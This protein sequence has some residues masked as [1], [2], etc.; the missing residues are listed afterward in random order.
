[1]RKG[2]NILFCDVCGKQRDWSIE[3]DKFYW[4]TLNNWNFTKT[5]Y[6]CSIKCGHQILHKVIDVEGIK[7]YINEC[8][9]E[10]E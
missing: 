5:F 3:R 8:P 6:C 7:R 4:F 1:M 2:F 10:K 9:K